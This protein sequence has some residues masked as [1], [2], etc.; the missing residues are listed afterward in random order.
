MDINKVILCKVEHS[1]HRMEY[2]T[3][4]SKGNDQLGEFGILLIKVYE[5][6]GCA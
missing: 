5:Y 4:K 3:M 1:I 6:V 2:L